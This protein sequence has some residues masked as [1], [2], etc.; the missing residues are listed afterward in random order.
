MKIIQMNALL[1]FTLCL[2]YFTYGM[3]I[4]CYHDCNM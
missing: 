3:Q 2:F 1:S 4:I